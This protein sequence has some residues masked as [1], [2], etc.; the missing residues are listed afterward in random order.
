MASWT[1][2]Q[3]VEQMSGLVT[4]ALITPR[5]EVELEKAASTDC[6]AALQDSGLCT[7]LVDSYLLLGQ[8]GSL[9]N[10]ETTQLPPEAKR[11]LEDKIL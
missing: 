9:A 10:L 3:A 11:L 6:L 5:M 2:C 1:V 7:E 4:T 8:A